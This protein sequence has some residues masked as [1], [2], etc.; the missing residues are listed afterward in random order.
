MLEQVCKVYEKLFEKLRHASH[1]LHA[2]DILSKFRKVE[3]CEKS[4]KIKYNKKKL[5]L[6]NKI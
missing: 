5:T 3:N 4:T 1:W 2:V 6:G